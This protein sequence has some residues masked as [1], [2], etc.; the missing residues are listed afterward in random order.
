MPHRALFL[1]RDGVINERLLTLVRRPEQFRF[2]P[3]VPEAIARAHRAGWKVVVAT[4]QWPVGAGVIAADAL[5]RI[6]DLMVTGVEN[7]GGRID[8]IYAC[9]HPP[10][11]ACEC[12]KPAPGMLLRAAREHDL[13]LGSSWMV[14]DQLKDLAAGRAAGC[15]T[16]LV[17]PTLRARLTGAVRHADLLLPGVPEVVAHLLERAHPPAPGA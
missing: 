12:A 10:R 8:A 14:G 3:G 16:V 2:R 1:D 7:A 9:V 6:H 11:Q 13:H 15:R 17:N 4:N 5:A